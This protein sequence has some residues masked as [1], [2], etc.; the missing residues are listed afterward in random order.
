[1]EGLTSSVSGWADDA[2]PLGSPSD[3]A[4]V[5]DNILHPSIKSDNLRLA[6]PNLL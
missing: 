5:D 4:R 2:C 6:I 3:P 1:M